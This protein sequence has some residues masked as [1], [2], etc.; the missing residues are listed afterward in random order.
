[1]L[2]AVIIFGTHKKN[3]FEDEWRIG[4]SF[5][6]TCIACLLS[7][8]HVYVATF[9]IK[10]DR[11]TS[12]SNTFTPIY[13]NDGDISR[14]E[15]NENSRLTTT[16]MDTTSANIGSVP[17]DNW[18]INNHNFFETAADDDVSKQNYREAKALPDKK[19]LVSLTCDEGSSIDTDRS[20]RS[21]SVTSGSS[22]EDSQALPSYISKESEGSEMT[23]R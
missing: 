13:G 7:M 6:V 4:W 9:V 17:R 8:L 1:M 21:S 16:K 14:Y 19:D 12:S 3:N 11:T 10:N 23:W 20:S 5:Y 18:N 22:S 15:M 2:L